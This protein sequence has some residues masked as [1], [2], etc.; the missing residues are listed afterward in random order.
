MPAVGHDR[1]SFSTSAGE[2]DPVLLL[3]FL[4]PKRQN[5]LP[6]AHAYSSQVSKQPFVPSRSE[7]SW[8]LGEQDADRERGAERATGDFWRRGAGVAEASWRGH[9]ASR[10]A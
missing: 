9:S 1:V 10:V 4:P 3:L 8:R 6:S 7:A 2:T 5:V